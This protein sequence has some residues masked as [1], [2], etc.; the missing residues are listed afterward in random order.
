MPRPEIDLV[1]L[2]VKSNILFLIKAKSYLDSPGVRFI[3]VN[4][5]DKDGAERYKLFT[6]KEF[7]DV[8]T[9]E[10]RNDF[11]KKG[12]INENTQISYALAAGKIHS[13]DE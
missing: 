6:N 8:V 10:I 11:L 3:D 13:N 2:N 1:A 9:T 5:Q 12:L 4:G 7:R